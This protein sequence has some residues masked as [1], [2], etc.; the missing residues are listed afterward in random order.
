[1]GKSIVAEVMPNSHDTLLQ[2]CEISQTLGTVKDSYFRKWRKSEKNEFGMARAVSIASG[3]HRAWPHRRIQMAASGPVFYNRPDT[4]FGVCEAIGQ[5]FG[6]NANVIRVAFGAC[7]LINPI[8][9]VCVYALL[10][11]AVAISR[12]AVPAVAKR[13]VSSGSAQAP[14]AVNDADDV[15]FAQAA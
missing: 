8:A 1:V 5:D 12:I 14:E 9:V 13:P 10:A 4:F 11:A 15:T 3:R 7:V 6:I 2:H